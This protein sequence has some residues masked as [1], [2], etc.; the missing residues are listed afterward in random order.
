MIVMPTSRRFRPLAVKASDTR[1]RLAN[2]IAAVEL[3]CD[4][5]KY[6]L[7]CPSLDIQPGDMGAHDIGIEHGHGT[8]RLRIFCGLTGDLK[9]VS[10]IRAKEMSHEVEPRGP[11]IERGGIIDGAIGPVI[12]EDAEQ[13]RIIFGIS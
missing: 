11:Q 6:T 8:R 7:Y 1:A 3:T 2:C 4:R 12:T 5:S 13:F 9:V 10:E